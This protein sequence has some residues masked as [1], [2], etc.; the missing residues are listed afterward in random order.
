MKPIADQ[1]FCIIDQILG[2]AGTVLDLNFPYPIPELIN[3]VKLLFLDIRNIIR[4]DCFEMGGFGG[5]LVTNLV[6]VPAIIGGTCLLVY[7]QQRRTLTALVAAGA[8]D[9]SGLHVL[10][11][12]LK[13]RLMIGIFLVCKQ[14]LYV[15]FMPVVCPY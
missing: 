4:L 10:Q 5:K 9:E 15:L 1:A 12:Q 2:Q 8:S 11:V 6:V 7:M 14:P 3:L 13:H